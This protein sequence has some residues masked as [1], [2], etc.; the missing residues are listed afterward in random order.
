[1]QF[2]LLYLYLFIQFLRHFQSQSNTQKSRN[3]VFTRFL[4]TSYIIE[5]ELCPSA[6]KYDV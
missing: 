4:R 1:M 6:N 3:Q 5:G 2:L